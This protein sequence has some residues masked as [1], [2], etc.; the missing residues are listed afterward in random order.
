MKRNR[1]ILL[2]LS[3]F[4]MGAILLSACG[5]A[6]ATPTATPG[7]I[8]FTVGGR[9]QYLIAIDRCCNPCDDRCHD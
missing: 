7:P 3:I 8:T 4:T 6:A 2:V 5:S 1:T 9:G